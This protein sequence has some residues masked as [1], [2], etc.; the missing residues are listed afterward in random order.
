MLASLHPPLHPRMRLP[1]VPSCS[2]RWVSAREAQHQ[3]LCISARTSITL[4]V[5]RDLAGPSG[6]FV[7]A[8]EELAMIVRSRASSYDSRRRP[9]I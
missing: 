7:R 6:H 4:S 2:P 5:R 3:I 8:T 9:D 1:A